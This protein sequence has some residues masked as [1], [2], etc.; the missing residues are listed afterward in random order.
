MTLTKGNLEP[1]PRRIGLKQKRITYSID[2]VLILPQPRIRKIGFFRVLKTRRSSCNFKPIKK[3]QLADFLGHAFR[4]SKVGLDSTGRLS[5]HRASPSAGGIHPID[6][7]IFNFPPT[8]RDIYYYD[9]FGHTL[10]RI[11]AS[12]TKDLRGLREQVLSIKGEA[13]GTC[14]WFAAQSHLTSAKY[15]QA[16]SLIWR[17]SGCL[18]MTAY[19]VATALNLKCC[20]IGITGNNSFSSLD[21]QKHKLVGVGG[22]LLGS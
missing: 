12:T 17:D 6:T 13:L 4:T 16:E 19:M 11:V 1:R 21:S 5:Q 9:P 18:I 10:K 3:S 20:A 7:F 8:S 15:H 14:V 22:I 2:R